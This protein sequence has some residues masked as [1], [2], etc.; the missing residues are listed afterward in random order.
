MV[1]LGRQ[2]RDLSPWDVRG[3][4]QAW[5]PETVLIAMR[6]APVWGEWRLLCRPVWAD[7]CGIL[8]GLGGGGLA[9]LRVGD[10]CPG[11]EDGGTEG[12]GREDRTLGVCVCVYVLAAGGASHSQERAGHVCLHGCDGSDG[13]VDYCF[14][15]KPMER[16]KS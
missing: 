9:K 5:R 4:C 10:C 13:D 1:G 15:K 14:Q 7:E 8:G 11:P 12:G 3:K 16:Q 2:R 6:A